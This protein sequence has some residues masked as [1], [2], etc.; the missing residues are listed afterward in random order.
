MVAT[1]GLL[2]F[3]L[4]LTTRYELAHGYSRSLSHGRLSTVGLKDF[5]S[6]EPRRKNSRG[7]P[8]SLCLQ[9]PE[10]LGGQNGV[11]ASLDDQKWEKKFLLLEEFKN[12]EGHCDVP[13][14][15]TEKDGKKLGYWIVNQR[16]AK[17]RGD[18]VQEREKR[19][20]DLGI[21][22]NIEKNSWEKYM[23]LMERFQHREGHCEVPSRHL[24]QGLKL[25]VWVR[26]Q[27]AF[28]ARGVLDSARVQSLDEIGF[29][30]ELTMESMWVRNL[31]LLKRYKE[32]EGHCNVPRS[33]REDGAPLGRW[34]ATQ[35]SQK[36]LDQDRRQRLEEVGL[37][38]DGFLS[39]QQ[40]K[41]M[42][43][44]EGL[45]ILE[46]FRSREGHCNP[47]YAHK[48]EGYN[49]GSWVTTQRGLKN[50]GRLV[51][52]RERSLEKIGFVFGTKDERGGKVEPL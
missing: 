32:R 24:E 15:Y 8:S 42:R 38:M 44:E 37:L 35:R 23:S 3:L 10:R 21:S 13:S 47:P 26:A 39:Y 22:W 11:P 19:L 45:S 6:T 20:D 14:L 33:H 43:W 2:L 40:R 28:Q 49:L 46:T 9:P 5:S 52:E 18:I 12:R 29:V 17:R 7:H 36:T 16:Q 50:K 51:P 31:S 34:V 4:A 41:D 25:G 1:G 48:E 30:W 27:R